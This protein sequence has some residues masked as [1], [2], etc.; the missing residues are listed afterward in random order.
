M[1][2]K[3]PPPPK[4]PKDSKAT[5]PP[6]S[7]PQQPLQQEPAET[8]SSAWA[9]HEGH[10][11]R[12]AQ[13]SMTSSK[14]KSSTRQGRQSPG[15]H[16][17]Q[18]ADNTSTSLHGSQNRQRDTGSMASTMNTAGS[19]QRPLQDPL[20]PDKAIPNASIPDRIAATALAGTLELLR[21]AGG[22]TLSTTGKLV[23][24]PL[25]VTRTLLLPHLFAASMDYIQ[26][27]TPNRVMDW[28]R[29]V[30]TSVHHFI[31]VLV[32]TDKGK[33]FWNRMV[34]F[35]AHTVECLASDTSRQVLIDGMT[36]IVRFAEALA[37]PEFETWLHQLA[38][39]GC[40]LVDAFASGRNKQLWHDFTQMVWSAAEVLS[41]PE[42]TV[43]MAEVTAYLCH[44]LEMEDARIYDKSTS[45]QRSKL[46]R[47]RAKRQQEYQA[48]MLLSD[49]NATLEQA[50]LSSLGA[51]LD[52]GSEHDESAPSFVDLKQEDDES[53]LGDE[54]HNN[55]PGAH[56]DG[57]GD[58]DQ[59]SSV[60]QQ[61]EGE[62]KEQQ[63]A[64]TEAE[65]DLYKRARD[66]INIGLL[67]EKI[68]KNETKPR[69]IVTTIPPGAVSKPERD[70]AESRDKN[71]D[72]E[73]GFGPQ[74]ESKKLE[75]EKKR[76][77]LK[78]EAG[79]DAD[80]ADKPN[81]GKDKE[82]GD[83]VDWPKA[84]NPER[85]DGE[86]PV[87]HFFRVLDEVLAQNR[88]TAMKWAVQEVEKK[89]GNRTGGRSKSVL[90]GVRSSQKNGSD[91][92][93]QRISA[94][95]ADLERK[96]AGNRT[97]NLPF[98]RKGRLLF[99]M[100]ILAALFAA[101]AIAGFACYGLYSFLYP[102]QAGS[103]SQ[104][105]VERSLLYPGHATTNQEIVIRVVREVVH[106]NKDGKPLDY[107]ES[108]TVVS[109]EGI[110]RLTN[111]IAE[112]L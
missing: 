34:L 16:Q 12:T 76:R 46:R 17:Q 11:T 24:P 7:T 6:R 48:G 99:A 94:I 8:P 37:T 111:C 51:P 106:T 45:Q 23:A 109:Q 78:H 108:R 29:L 98:S 88:E 25:H 104:L 68:V 21:V 112:A 95:R 33:S 84:T 81:D 20:P 71:T 79:A 64:D 93:K 39:T 66:D 3:S 63:D 87:N 5:A 105:N 31:T 69:V 67:R 82:E 42:T 1:A 86:A 110:D 72:L 75:S 47:E 60:R 102:G 32:N 38:T 61:V 90:S 19:H 55:T 96:K 59:G 91:S 15:L 9:Q 54:G 27:A 77:A 52:D 56:D 101:M 43:A 26:H 10:G 41:A 97:S 65:G 74:V 50:I 30:S 100:V 49:P 89:E 58:W 92:I 83:A 103:V 44:A 14:A 2:E 36:C 70:V 35:L 107:P 18:A 40:R 85:K 73:D 13:S 22:F 80:F 53:R 57:T 28:I 4:Y 62:N